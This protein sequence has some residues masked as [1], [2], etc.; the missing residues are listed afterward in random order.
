MSDVH[1]FDYYGLHRELEARAV[2]AEAERDALAERVTQLEAFILDA[3]R[4]KRT[5][6][7]VTSLIA[8]AQRLNLPGF[9]AW[10]AEQETQGPSE[11]A[12]LR[13]QVKAARTTAA[14]FADPD[15]GEH[16]HGARILRA[17]DEVKP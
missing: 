14:E 12:T 8:N 10:W 3:C 15:F 6:G 9:D 5:H 11:L 2:K 7:A 13:A 17:M 16:C 1:P 4:E